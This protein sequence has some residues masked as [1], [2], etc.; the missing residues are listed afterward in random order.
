[1]PVINHLEKDALI[2][3][4]VVCQYYVGWWIREGILKLLGG[5]AGS[6]VT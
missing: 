5:P 3:H 4:S 2:T 6:L 1:M